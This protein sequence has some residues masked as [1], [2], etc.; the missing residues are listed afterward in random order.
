FEVA[1][2]T[3]WITHAVD[4]S[5]LDQDGRFGPNDLRLLKNESVA[6]LA[7]IDRGDLLAAVEERE[8]KE[9]RYSVASYLQDLDGL[10]Y[11]EVVALTGQNAAPIRAAVKQF[12][13]RQL[14]SHHTD[15]LGGAWCNMYF[16]P[17]PRPTLS[18]STL[19][20]LNEAIAAFNVQ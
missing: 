18:K 3:V 12:R 2:A 8:K 14:C 20:A 9:S 16:P 4:A 6:L 17:P 15:D 13:M 11:D 7:A 1:L 5:D 10:G 19:E